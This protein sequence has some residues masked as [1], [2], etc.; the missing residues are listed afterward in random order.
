MFS[1]SV[2]IVLFNI[3]Q[4]KSTVPWLCDSLVLV[5]DS[6][7]RPKTLIQSSFCWKKYF[8]VVILIAHIF[9]TDWKSIHVVEICIHFFIFPSAHV[10]KL[11]PFRFYGRK[12]NFYPLYLIYIKLRISTCVDIIF[13][14][15]DA[16]KS[17]SNGPLIRLE[18]YQWKNTMQKQPIQKFKSIVFFLDQ[19]QY[20]YHFLNFNFV[21][22]LLYA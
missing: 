11:S 2:H 12:W 21:L 4:L 14:F 16:F 8:P 22:C 20:A 10:K 15:I 6:Q 13:V 1:C 5:F 19:P 9:I 18:N 7:R 3:S 17:Y